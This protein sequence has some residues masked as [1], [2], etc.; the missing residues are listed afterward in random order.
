MQ[1]IAVSIA[2]MILVFSNTTT[3]FA[4]NI[5]EVGALGCVIDKWDE[6]EIEKG[7]KLVAYAGRCVEI[8]DNPAAPKATEICTGSYEYLA[9][10]SWKGNGT[11]IDTYKTGG[12]KTITFEEGSHL[13]EFTYQITGGTGDYKGATGG[14]TYTN[15]QLTDTMTGGRFKGTMTVP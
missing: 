2:L 12:T 4:R 7:H 3:A 13:K 10:G 15:D 9:D 8:P 1:I 11:C 14:G 5:E 6:K